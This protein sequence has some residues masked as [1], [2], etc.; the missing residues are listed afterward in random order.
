MLKQRSVLPTLRYVGYL[1]LGGQLVQDK[2]VK[3]GINTFF[4]IL[5]TIYGIPCQ[6]RICKGQEG[7]EKNCIL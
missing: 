1:G 5:G 4:F 6:R 3:L 2:P 7:K